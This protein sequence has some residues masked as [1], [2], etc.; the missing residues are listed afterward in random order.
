MYFYIKLII[1]N[2]SEQNQAE[3]GHP[4]KHHRCNEVGCAV[5]TGA[6]NCQLKSEVSIGK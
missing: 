6:C 4:A 1:Y 2:Q 3:F 5:R